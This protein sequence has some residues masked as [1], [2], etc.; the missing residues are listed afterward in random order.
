MADRKVHYEAAFEQLLRDRGVP[1]VAVDEAKRALFAQSALKS[2]DFVVYG[3]KAGNL[4]VDVKGRSARGGQSLQTWVSQQDVQDLSQWES[5]FGEGFRGLLL[6]AY[7]VDPPLLDDPEL[8]RH[9][10]RAY[11]MVGVDLEDYR[12]HMRRRSPRW[13]TVAI[14]AGDFRQLARPIDQWL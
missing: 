11:R 8:V 6:F 14:P 4:L 7:W 12:N 13:G 3:G 2:F 1:Y 10:D 9:G 5:I